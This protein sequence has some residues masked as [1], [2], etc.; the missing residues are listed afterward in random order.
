VGTRKGGQEAGTPQPQA[1]AANAKIPI[2]RL[3]MAVIE[4]CQAVLRFFAL[5]GTAAG[6]FDRGIRILA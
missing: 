4:E 2:G 1:F 5:L 6:D 3:T